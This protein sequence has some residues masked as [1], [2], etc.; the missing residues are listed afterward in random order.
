MNK[1]KRNGKD[2]IQW[3][4][5]TWTPI[6]GC[7]GPGGTE[8]NPRM[9]HYCYAKKI[10][11]RFAGTKGYQYGFK[12][13]FHPERLNE[14]EKLRTPSKIFVC[15]TGDMFGNAVPN[16]WIDQVIERMRECP[17]HIFQLLT[18]NPERLYDYPKLPGNCWIGTSIDHPETAHARS[19]TLNTAILDNFKFLSIEPLLGDVT[20]YVDWDGIDWVIVGQQSGKG[21]KPPEDKWVRNIIT[22]TSY[23]KI[24]LFVKSPLYAF[25][26]IQE[27]PEE[28]L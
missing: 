4:N 21:A 23:R 24:P 22:A 10:A 9:C 5:M 13:T 3:T 1:Q 2:G 12:P 14:P 8:E 18:K 28:M 17:R 20:P 27:W 25:F 15:S 26:P 6:T 16:E 19:E 11:D 7:Y